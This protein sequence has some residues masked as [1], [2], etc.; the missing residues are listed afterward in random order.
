M[1]RETAGVAERVGVAGCARD[2]GC[3]EK[4]P[5]KRDRDKIVPGLDHVVQLVWAEPGHPLPN[6]PTDP[7]G[8]RLPTSISA[9]NLPES[10][11]SMY[12]AVR[13]SA[14]QVIADTPGIQ[15]LRPVRQHRGPCVTSGVSRCRRAIQYVK[16][17]PGSTVHPGRRGPC[18]LLDCAGRSLSLA[19]HNIGTECKDEE[20]AGRRE[21]LGFQD[22]AVEM[23]SR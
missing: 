6:G 19:S 22:S 13:S 2:P 21:L 4:R 9:W 20:P 5:R 12:I 11:S 23:Q 7:K 18:V 1:E 3:V 14:G 16:T 10:V 8:R 15:G 17:G